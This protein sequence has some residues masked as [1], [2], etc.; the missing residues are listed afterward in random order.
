MVTND[1]GVSVGIGGKR[2][3]APRCSVSPTRT[4]PPMTTPT[5]SPGNASSIDARS[6]PN[7]SCAKLSASVR[8]V[9]AFVTRIPR[10]NRPEQIR[11][12]ATRSRWRGSMLACTLNTSAANGASTGRSV[13]SSIARGCADGASS[14]STS[15]SSPTPKF[16]AAEP[17]SIGISSPRA[18]RLGV[19]LV[20]E[21]VHELQLLVRDGPG[22]VRPAD[23]ASS[24]AITVSSAIAL[25]PVT[26]VNWWKLPLRWSITPLEAAREA[27]RPR[28]RHQRQPERL[29]QVIDHPERL[30]AGAVVLV[31]EREQRDPARAGDLEQLL[32]LR[33]HAAGR[34]DQD[35][36]R[37]RRPRARAACPRRSPCARAC[38]AG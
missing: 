34:V 12:N 15:S 28:D 37:S 20:A 35:H 23:S 26:R 25:P 10:S 1:S 3:V 8:P 9:R 19:E 32:G 2:T 14:R 13:P 17:N 36:G 18:K 11:T 7:T 22:R 29:G 30:H 5:T 38:R 24:R 31:H 21:L 4:S 27:D 16:H 33:L 6:C